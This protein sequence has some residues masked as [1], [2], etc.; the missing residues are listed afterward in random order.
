MATELE[1]A[2]AP[3]TK[4]SFK[5][6]FRAWWDGTDLPPPDAEA[7]PPVPP[8]EGSGAEAGAEAPTE[9]APP[10]PPAELLTMG[11]AQHIWGEGFTRPGG[12][13]SILTLVKPFALDPSMTVMDF[14]AG[15]GGGT[16]AVSSQFD[17]WVTGFEPSATYATAGQEISVRKGAKKAD[18]RHYTPQDFQ[19]KAASYDCIYSSEA[20]FTLPDK[21]R[22]L[23]TFER[24][25]KARGQI[26]ITDFVRTKGTAADDPRLA[27]FPTRTKHPCNFWSAEEYLAKF[28]AL[29][30]DIRVDEDQTETYRQTV[31]ESWVN[32]TED[33]AAGGYA[34]AN[35]EALV[36]EV[37]LWTQRIAALDSGA[38]QLR[39]F[40]GIKMGSSKI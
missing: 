5:V 12:A 9:E 38:L 27:G 15:L 10:P 34:K 31:L 14:G 22:L 28:K 18:I 13:A 23:A 29:K 26:S 35:P 1:S 21:E 6:R 2:E 3:K 16:R 11:V 32:F 39:R 17:I 8:A 19:P 40:Y 30:L 25:L 33:S 37:M 20:L 24:A 7:P 36:A 4:H